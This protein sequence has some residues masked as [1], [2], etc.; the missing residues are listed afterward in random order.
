M[1]GRRTEAPFVL[2][3]CVETYDARVASSESSKSV[4][5]GDGGVHL[6]VADE[7]GLFENL[8]CVGLTG[9]DMGCLLNL[10]KELVSAECVAERRTVE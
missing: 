10:E 7:M 5:L 3:G 6:V 8:Y 2:E 1:S 9:D 4:A